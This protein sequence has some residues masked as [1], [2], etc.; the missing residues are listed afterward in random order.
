[1]TDEERLLWRHLW[2]IPVEGTHFRRQASVGAYYP[3]F[4]SHRLKLIVE[5]DGAHHSADDQLRRDEVR[6]RWFE[7]QGYRVVRFW[8]HEIKKRTGFCARYNL[9]GDGR[10]EI[11]PA[12][13]RWCRRYWRLR[14]RHPAP[15]LRADPPHQGEGG[16]LNYA[17]PALGTSLRGNPRPHA[18]QGGRRPQ[19]DADRRSGRG[20]S[21]L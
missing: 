5:V 16:E 2:R 20:G 14:G 1:M 10:T 7:S 18:A 13:A 17:R 12:S 11:T 19:E 8:N 9:C 21:D 3:D 6:T 4:I 15:A